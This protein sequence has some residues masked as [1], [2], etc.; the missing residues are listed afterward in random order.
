[1]QRLTNSSLGPAIAQDQDSDSAAY[2]INCYII[3]TIF[4]YL[5]TTKVDFGDESALPD[6]YRFDLLIESVAGV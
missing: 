3:E 5:Q 2:L 1:M 4:Y 6:N